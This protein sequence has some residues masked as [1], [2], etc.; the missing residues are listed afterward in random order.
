MARA[1]PV[2]T[3]RPERFATDISGWLVFLWI[4]A[5]FGSFR[6]RDVDALVGQNA[7]DAQVAFQ[8][9]SWVALA[10]IAALLVL[11]RRT[12]W[13]VFDGGPLFWYAGF[14][15][16]AALSVVYSIS[17]AFSAF[18][19]FQIAVFVM[20]LASVGLSAKRLLYWISAYA[21]LNWILVALGETG[22]T[23]GMDWIVGAEEMY[24]R[25]GGSPGEIWRL[26]TAIGHPSQLSVVA[27]MGAVAAFA[28]DPDDRTPWGWLLFGFL[29][30]TVLATVSRTAI[31][32]MAL[33]LVIVMIL[34]RR[35]H[36]LVLAG[37]VAALSVIF[38]PAA[39]DDAMEYFLRGQSVDAFASLTGR[40]SIYEI[41]LERAQASWWGEGFRS[42]RADP[43]IGRYWGEGVVHAHNLFLQAMIETGVLGA[44]MATLCVFSLLYW[45][46]RLAF[47]GKRLRAHARVAP[48]GICGPIL[49]FSALDSG[50]VVN[51]GPFVAA[52]IAQ[53]MVVRKQVHE[54]RLLGRPIVQDSPDAQGYRPSTGL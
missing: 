12:V 54:T 2:R 15:V 6:T 36:I 30:V 48:I 39:V 16:F 33:G 29:F 1:R 27:A 24:I 38:V 32:G 9:G 5:T 42:L 8:I 22:L 17:P 3:T 14:M 53:L 43:L 21:A 47:P 23:F 10:A 37:S 7:I 13:W 4:V 50:F 45:S 41:A 40:S 11:R 51:L 26:S 28:N 49:A 52:F 46:V 20:L 25:Y 18:Y 19:V 34:Q 31:A 35:T 44:I